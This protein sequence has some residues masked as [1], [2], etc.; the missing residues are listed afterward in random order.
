[1]DEKLGEGAAQALQSRELRAGDPRK[2]TGSE[3]VAVVAAKEHSTGL[4]EGKM[5][6]RRTFR[7][8]GTSI[9]ELKRTMSGKREVIPTEEEEIF[10]E[11]VGCFAGLNALG[12]MLERLIEANAQ[13][14]TEQLFQEVGRIPMLEQMP[15]ND[16][17]RQSLIDRKELYL[18]SEDAGL[19]DSSL[20]QLTKRVNEV[21][22]T[23]TNL[24]Q[25]RGDI[26][27]TKRY[28]N[29][30]TSGWIAELKTQLGNV[31]RERAQFVIAPVS[32]S[33]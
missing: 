19:I 17:F 29:V 21:V 12:Q 18:D 6:K 3:D 5:G 31:Q 26:L 4:H 33:G 20:D 10:V 14:M 32:N 22:L 15:L 7:L 13:D 24:L 23:L 1:M 11:A 8:Q 2:D 16:I 30:I 25:Q 9:A 27:G 28:G